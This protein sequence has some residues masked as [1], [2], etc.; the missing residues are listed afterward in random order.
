MIVNTKILIAMK[1][2]LLPKDEIKE[3]NLNLFI[4]SVLL[5]IN[6]SRPIICIGIKIKLTEQ[7]KII[8]IL[9]MY[10]ISK[11]NIKT[12]GIHIHNPVNM[13]KTAPILR[14]KWK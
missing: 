4:T 11:T 8:N 13:A 5:R 2:I 14:T 7:N 9:F 1:L 3:L 10:I 6:P 12:L